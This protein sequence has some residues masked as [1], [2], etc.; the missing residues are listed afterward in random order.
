MDE[1]LQKAGE[2]VV[3]SVKASDAIKSV[4]GDVRK[5]MAPVAALSNGT[6]LHVDG[7][8][9]NASLPKFGEVLVA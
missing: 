7:R 4:Q 3:E 8:S 5:A 2:T 6:L 1:N 9:K